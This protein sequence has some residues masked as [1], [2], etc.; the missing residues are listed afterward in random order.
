MI[1]K[2][3]LL[4]SN[5]II[6]VILGVTTLI[7]IL[8]NDKA[9]QYIMDKLLTGNKIEYKKI[10]GSMAEGLTLHDVSYENALSSKSIKISYDAKML[11]SSSP[12]IKLIQAEDLI[13]DPKKFPVSQEESKE[14]FSMLSFSLK[15]LVL[16][17]MQVI[18]DEKPI[19]FDINASDIKYDKKLSVKR[20][21][22]NL[23]SSYGALRVDAQIKENSLK[24]K[25]TASPSEEIYDTYLGFLWGIP[26]TL[27]I[28]ID[29]DL[30]QVS[31]S[32]KLENIGLVYDANLSISNADIKLKYF[33]HDGYF[34]LDADYGLS[35]K[36]FQSRINQTAIFTSFGAYYSKLNALL[37]KTPLKLP[38]KSVSAQIA[39]DT[40]DMIADIDTP[41]I[42]IE[43][44]GSQ[45]Q[46]FI[47]KAGNKPMPLSFTDIDILKND[48]LE[49]R[50]EAVLDLS[51]FSLQG[52]VHAKNIYS[53]M[54]GAFESD[55]GNILYI[56]T[57]TPK[58]DTDLFKNSKIEFF[59]PLG[60]ILYG[61]SNE[62]IVNLDAN[63]LNL[64]MFKNGSVLNGWGN[65]A[66]NQ[67]HI[68]GNISEEKPKLYCNASIPSVYALLEEFS[69]NSKN[70]NE[71]FDAELTIDSVFTLSEKP[72]L[73]TK[74]TIPWYVIQTDS[75]TSYQ[76]E[77]VFAHAKIMDKKI[78]IYRYN[79]DI[80]N[81][82]ISS[83]KPSAITFD[84]NGTIAFEE[85]W[86]YDNLSLK[87]FLN[88][89]QMKGNLKLYSEG[90]RYEGEEGNVSAKVD[91]TAF[92]DENNTQNI[93]GIITLLDGTIKY[94]T[95]GNYKIT[96]DDIIIIQDIKAPSKINRHLNLHINSLKPIG[97]K[98]KD[99]DIYFSPDF[100]VT[101]EPDDKVRL[102]G[103]LGMDE[104]SI[105]GGGKIFELK[106]SEIYFYGANPVNPYLNMHI[107]HYI[108]TDDII[109]E[110]FITNTLES[111]V[112]VFS[113]SPAMSQDDIM[114]YIL[115]GEPASSVFESSTSGTTKASLGTLFFGTGLKTI[116]SDTTGINI[117][118]LN[119]ITNPEGT[120]GYEIGARFNK[121]IRIIYSNDN[122]Q[123]VTLQ[124]SLS[125][126]IRI[127]V[128]VHETG[129]GVT[130]LYV[131]DYEDLHY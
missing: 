116:F 131:K 63:L 31:L 102:Y 110:I 21:L 112:I 62:A 84:E 54:D 3:Y 55:D 70:E 49:M 1:K 100:T 80:L 101:Q 94:E 93:D 33:V 67:F 40:V 48:I 122:T 16:N 76:G 77:N 10:E 129:Q 18:V 2:I 60:I 52:S 107:N 5:L 20:I 38:F 111:P 50:A 65:L 58:A 117:D 90:F 9:S 86:I 81:H 47:F 46:K 56:G 120:F 113:S 22:L 115:F 66:Q 15:Q 75:Q 12:A 7:F 95:S 37:T 89:K 43:A 42:H 73:E 19:T 72:A 25:T 53:E 36:Q 105:S 34:T 24:A 98:T 130:V 82:Q 61:N 85:F 14:E 35:Y 64:T 45:Y 30:E 57:L 51:P 39:G 32:T 27:D 125:N 118:R 97:Y 87:G 59:S 106:K 41:K 121:Q 17:N 126:S 74:I 114:S 44:L 103:M 71:F 23:A 124:Y 128:D 83:E 119:I 4:I 29:A 11:V 26:K 92:F 88:P 99:I 104:G 96:D 123:S 28:D 127:D 79:I 6:F 13:I 91:I 69:L 109:I 8:S 108:D 68:Y 78:N